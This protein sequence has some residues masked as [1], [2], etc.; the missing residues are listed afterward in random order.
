[1]KIKHINIQEPVLYSSEAADSIR[2][3]L[4]DKNIKSFLI[5]HPSAQYKYKIY[6]KFLRNQLLNSLNDLGIPILITGSKNKLDIAIAKEIPVLPNVY[7]FIGETTLEEYIVLSDLAL[8]YIGMDTLNMHIAASQSKRIFAIFGPTNL[9]MWSPW[10]NELNK[11]ASIDKV[12]Q[13][14]GEVTI[15]QSNLPCVACGMA[16]CDDLQGRSECLYVID[17]IIIFNEIKTWHLNV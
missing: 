10:S 1:M 15:F 5:F 3:R 9:K 17:P 14:Y 16:G 8:A 13:N 11:C 12:I 2:K 4:V 7:N 6:P